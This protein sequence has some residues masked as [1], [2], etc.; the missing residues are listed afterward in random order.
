LPEL[1]EN[2]SG[3]ESTQFAISKMVFCVKT[4]CFARWETVPFYGLQCMVL[5][6]TY[7]IFL[8]KDYITRLMVACIIRLRWPK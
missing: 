5:G 7:T 8:D 1:S 6:C 2:S 4:K 3:C